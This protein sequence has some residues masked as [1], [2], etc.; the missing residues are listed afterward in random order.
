M[1]G[2]EV[3]SAEDSE[4]TG[5][6][7]DY[8]ALNKHIVESAD[9]EEET[10]LVGYVSGIYDLGTQKLPDAEYK[11][12]AGDEA[13]SIG[14]LT[15]K[16][17]EKIDKGLI[18]KFDMAYDVDTKSHVIKKFV[19]QKNRQAVTYSVDF[20][21]IMIDTA[22][23]FGKE[24][25]P[26]ALRLYIGG[27]WYNKPLGKMV[28]N[29][30]IPLKRTNDE[31][32]G[33]TLHPLSSFYKMAVA[34]KI[35]TKE[36]PFLPEQIDQLLGKSLQFKAQV[37]LKPK[38][39]K[40]YYTE[41][42]GYVGALARGLNPIED[43]KT[44]LIMFNSEANDTETLKGLRNSVINTMALATNFE[45]SVIQKQLTALGRY[46]PTAKTA[47]GEDEVSEEV[48]AQ[49]IVDAANNSPVEDVGW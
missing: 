38:D 47:E 25:E 37:F 3:Y 19:P 4:G 6:T 22:S 28:V 9:I 15:E 33:W 14:E 39:G 5:S 26:K 45:G 29:S 35:I 12:D 24:P 1:S 31:K 34:S 32:V 16:Y 13:L 49:D 17:Q 43:V 10:T 8:V 46:T 41:K 40:E 7:I 30:V 23:F 27:D 48:T 20:P 2:F 36:Q 11:V 44:T 18:T 42:L 21:D